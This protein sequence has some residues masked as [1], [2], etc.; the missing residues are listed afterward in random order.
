MAGIGE[1]TFLGG[2]SRKLRRLQ[3]EEVWDDLKAILSRLE[4]SDGR[5]TAAQMRRALNLR[6]TESKGWVKSRGRLDWLWC[7]EAG[8]SGP[9]L[10][11][12]SRFS[13]PPDLLLINIARLRDQVVQG[14]IDI[15]VLVVASDSS[16]TTLESGWLSHSHALRA[17]QRIRADYSPIVVLGLDL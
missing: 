2:A 4:R 9:A 7:A 8:E 12:E 10:G 13:G 14:G 16:A 5:M 17:A 6:F 1:V 3:L 15:G 11:V